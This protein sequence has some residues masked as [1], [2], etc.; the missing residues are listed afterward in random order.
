LTFKILKFCFVPSW[1]FS[2]FIRV[3]FKRSNPLYPI[4]AINFYIYANAS[5][6]SVIVI[7]P[8]AMS[9]SPPLL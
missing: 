6:F 3:W 8:M 7:P 4:T 5:C 9:I 1:S 2:R